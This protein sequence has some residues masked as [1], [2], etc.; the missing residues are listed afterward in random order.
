[1]TLNL[2][3][4]PRTVNAPVD[5]VVEWWRMT[6][7]ATKSRTGRGLSSA[8]TS[9]IPLRKKLLRQSIEDD[10]GLGIAVQ[11]KVELRLGLG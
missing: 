4:K 7:E 6:T 8:A 5:M 10:E 11:G 9:T 2:S 1:M 3:L